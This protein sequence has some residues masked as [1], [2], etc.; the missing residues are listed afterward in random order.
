MPEVPNHAGNSGWWTAIAAF[1][2]YLA[3]L[4]FGTSADAACD[5]AMKRANAIPF[6]HEMALPDPEPIG[7]DDPDAITC[8]RWR[9]S[10]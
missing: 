5:E 4:L 7:T 9:I 10:D 1:L 8:I 2:A 3:Q 6:P